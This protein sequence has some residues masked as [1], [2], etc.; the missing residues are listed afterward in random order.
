LLIGPN[1]PL[2]AAGFAGFTVASGDATTFLAA[3]GN[4]GGGQ[5]ALM[6][7]AAAAYLNAVSGFYPLTPAQVVALVNGALASGNAATIESVKNQ[8]DALNNLGCGFDQLGRQIVPALPG[9]ALGDVNSDGKFDS[10]DLVRLFQA[11]HYEDGIERN[12]TWTEGDFNG[13][14][15]FDTRDL[16]QLFQ[17]G[18]YDEDRSLNRRRD[19]SLDLVFAAAADDEDAWLV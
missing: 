16:V 13:D 6:R 1:D 14:Q 15:E 17:E 9:V 8:L 10:S 4:G 3:L 11:G 2:S 18:R 5:N 19:R 7:H 12:S